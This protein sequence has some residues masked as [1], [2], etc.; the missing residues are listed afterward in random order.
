MPSD[1]VP[2]LAG[3]TSQVL[4]RLGTNQQEG[5]SNEFEMI[6]PIDSL[7]F[8]IQANPGVYVLLLGSGV[9]RVAQVPTGWEI[10][11]D[12]IRK[13]AVA[14][15][16]SAEPDPELWYRERYEEV[17]DY[18]ELINGL[19]KTQAERQQLL[20]S[21]FEPSQQEREEDAKQPTAAHKAVARLVAHGFVK[22]ILTTNFDRLVEK[23]LEDAGVEPTLLSS[24]DQVK[25][26]LPL[27]HTSHCVIKVHGDY[28]D[29]RIRNTP[30]ELEAYPVE[31]NRLLDQLFDEFGLVV[32]GWSADWDIALR[33]ALYRAPSRRFTTYWAVHGEASEAAQQLISQRRAQVIG[34]EDA[35]KFF[36]TVQQKVESIAQFSQPHPLSVEAAVTSL[37]T[38]LSEPRYRIRLSDLV[39]ETVARVVSSVSTQAFDANNPEPDTETLTARVRSY[40][41]ACSTLLSMAVVGG[42]WAEKDHFGVWQRALERLATARYTSGNPIWLGLQRYPATLTLYALGLGAL[43][44]NK[45]EFLD[46]MF[47]TTI[48]QPAHKSGALVQLLPPFSM[49]GSF[50]IQRA[51]RLL[52]GMERRHTPFNDR[53]HATLH[54]YISKTTHSNEQ[55]DLMFDK[56]EILMALGSAYHEKRPEGWYWAPL[57]SFV[58]RTQNRTQILEEIEESISTLQRESS[59]LRSGIFGETP[60]EC[61][62]SIKQFKE[63]IDRAARS[64]GLFW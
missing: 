1:P 26:M 52:E 60:E 32:C 21:Y 63:F 41:A 4:Q 56:I 6:D 19:A 3:P 54:Q 15:G 58:Y 61:M 8:S 29:T 64:M 51:M 22:V 10:T 34:V 11:L 25:G 38:Y 55:Y 53:V 5:R 16:E 7:A 30:S 33:D 49:F 37:K 47:S 23:A 27:V 62:V 28:L 35:D 57:G 36:E 50:D 45:L 20:R 24:P 48:P 46:R 18:S 59:F 12:L 2:V 42:A 14:Q 17:P 43:S 13:L 9:S 39:D 40:E 44:S 31:L